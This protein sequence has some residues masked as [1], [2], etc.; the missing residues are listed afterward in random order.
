MTMMKT[1]AALGVLL[2]AGACQR[3][4]DSGGIV[5]WTCLDCP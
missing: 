3:G 2:I 4:D 5:E 1:L